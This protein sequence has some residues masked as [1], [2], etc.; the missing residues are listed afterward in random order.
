MTAT[1]DSFV[2]ALKQQIATPKADLE[3]NIRALLSE[4][5]TKL[6]LV[7]Q[8]ELE[9]QNQALDQANQRLNALKLQLT[10]LEAQIKAE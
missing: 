4:M 3:Q 6:D 8:V 10:E 9:R 7:S 2:D 1:L 5:I